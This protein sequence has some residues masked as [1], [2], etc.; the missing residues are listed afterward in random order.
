[1][2]ENQMSN[3]QLQLFPYNQYTYVFNV[4]MMSVYYKIVQWFP[5]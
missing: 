5:T 3:A 1:M 4:Q 2:D